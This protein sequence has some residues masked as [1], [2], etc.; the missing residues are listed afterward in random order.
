MLAGRSPFGQ[1]PEPVGQEVHGTQGTP[2]RSLAAGLPANTAPASR[3]PALPSRPAVQG[4]ERPLV[5]QFGDAPT[6]GAGPGSHPLPG[7]SRRPGP[8]AARQ[9]Q[10]RPGQADEP[11]PLVHL[12]HLTSR[13]QEIPHPDELVGRPLGH[14][15]PPV[16]VD[17]GPSH[18]GRQSASC[19]DDTPWRGSPS[20]PGGR[21]GSSPAATA[22]SDRHGPPGAGKGAEYRENG[23][24]PARRGPASPRSRPFGHRGGRRGPGEEAKPAQPARASPP[25]RAHLT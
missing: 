17:S 19:R 12:H 24:P 5:N 13:A 2:P 15:P 10:A 9:P 8:E 25:P 21:R 3:R 11:E 4:S 18:C 23:A 20:E 22:P 1:V 16:R 14:D 6:A 7:L